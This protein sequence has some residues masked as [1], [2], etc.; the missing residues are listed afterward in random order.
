VDMK[1]EDIKKKNIHKVPD[2]YFDKLPQIIQSKAIN[3]KN[4][5][6]SLYGSLKYA[7]PAVIILA[8][9]VYFTLFNRTETTVSP[10]EMLA[11][12]ST[13]ELILYLE[14]SE[15]STEEIIESIDME[16]IE[17]DFEEDAELLN[18]INEDELDLLLE[19][20]GDEDI[21]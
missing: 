5:A 11:E 13:K 1:L 12:V 6:V 20:Y 3:S 18:D 14:D 15:I 10:E 9:T 17:L 21:L 4:S 16:S 19:E 8:I 7:L 2:E